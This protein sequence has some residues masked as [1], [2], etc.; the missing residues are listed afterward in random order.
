[1]KHS[2]ENLIKVAQEPP[3]ALVLSPMYVL[4]PMHVYVKQNNLKLALR[5]K[6]KQ[7]DFVNLTYLKA[8]KTT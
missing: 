2:S 7:L 3:A 1:M 8:Y 5:M 6:K 4:I